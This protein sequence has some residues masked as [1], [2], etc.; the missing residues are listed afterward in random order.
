MSS[1]IFLVLLGLIAALVPAEADPISELKSFSAF[2]SADL[3]QLKGDAKPV[4]GPAMN[5]TRFQSVQSAWISPGA[6]AQVSSA[7]RSFNPVRYPDLNVLLQ[8]NSSNFSSLSSAPNNSAV[9]W[10]KDATEKKSTDLQ[11]SNAE[12][13]K[14][15]G[16]AQFWSGILNAR[17][18]LGISAQPSYEHTGQNVRPGAEIQN[19][20]NSSA[21]SRARK[22]SRIGN[23]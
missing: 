19:F 15:G 4:R 13:A 5:N 20:A 16:F 18:A 9:Q 1:R 12:A 23:C 8:V 11:L 2:S 17:A 22:A 3:A 21:G 10:L 6:P 14:T 7:L